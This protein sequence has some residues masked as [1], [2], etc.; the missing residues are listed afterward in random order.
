M[1]NQQMATVAGG[2]AL[3]VALTV[4]LALTISS[5]IQ[6]TN[7]GGRDITDHA[8]LNGESDGGVGACKSDKSF[9]LHSTVTAGTDTYV[10]FTFVDTD[11]VRFLLLSNQTLN[12]TQAAGGTPAVDGKIVVSGTTVQDGTPSFL[13]GWVSMFTQSGAA[14]F[15]ANDVDYCRTYGTVGAAI[16]DT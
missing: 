11:S 5:R 4:V 6:A 1:R 13:T 10:T 8:L 16:G 2:I 14:G 3:A 15:G 9:I 7:S 12:V